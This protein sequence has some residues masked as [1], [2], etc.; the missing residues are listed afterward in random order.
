LANIEGPEL[1][2]TAALAVNGCGSKAFNRLTCVIANGNNQCAYGNVGRW[3]AWGAKTIGGGAQAGA[4]V[5][6]RGRG[7]RLNALMAVRIIGVFAVGRAADVV[8][9]DAWALAPTDL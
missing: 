6:S 5:P 7:A 4:G 3:G 9:V 8:S 1:S 2:K